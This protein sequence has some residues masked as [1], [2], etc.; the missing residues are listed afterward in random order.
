LCVEKYAR[1]ISSKVYVHVR[2]R[3]RVRVVFTFVLTSSSHHSQM[4]MQQ[5]EKNKLQK[6]THTVFEQKNK[7]KNK[8]NVYWDVP[9]PT[10]RSESRLSLYCRN[11]EDW[12]GSRCRFDR[13]EDQ[14]VD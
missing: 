10:G 8:G 14:K 9:V 12:V 2:I 1:S 13:G 4:R 3:I 11:R 5:K 6:H 7:D